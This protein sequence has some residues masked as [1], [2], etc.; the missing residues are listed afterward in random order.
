M[1]SISRRRFLAI[2]VFLG[3]WILIILARLFFLQILQFD[4]FTRDARRQQE[5]TVE[6]SPVRGVIYDRNH[7]PLAIS[8]EV[9]S[10][11]AVPGEIS[12]P[13]RTAKLL[14]AVLA[15]NAGDLQGRLQDSRS[16]RWVKRKVTAQEAARV[17]RLKLPGIYFQKESKRFY[18]KRELA[19]HVLGHVGLDDQGLAGIE[20]KFDE[21]LRGRPGKLLI[22]RD[23]RQRG[24][25]RAGLPPE[26]GENIVLTLD[27]NIQHIA[28]QELSAIVQKSRAIAGTVIVQDPHSGEILALVNQPSFNPN[29]YASHRADALRNWAISSAYEPGSTF[30][31]ITLAAALE[32]HLADP[33]EFIDCQMGSIILAGHRIR[34]HKPFGVLSVEQIFQ[35]SSDVGT[36]KLALRVGNE[37]MYRYLRLF[38]FGAPTG[39]ELPGE[40]IGLAKPPERWSKISIGAIAMGQEVGVT[41]LQMVTAASAVANGGWLVRPRMVLDP[42]RDPVRAARVS[43]RTSALPAAPLSARWGSHEGADRQR[44]LSPE[45]ALVLQQMMAQVVTIGTGKLARPEGYTAAGKTGTAQKID[46]ATRRY[47]ATDHVASFVGFAPVESPQFTI[48]VVL[49]SP[50]GYY[51]GGDIAA[52]VFKR[53]AEQIL[54]YRNVPALVPPSPSMLRA[55]RKIPAPSLVA[56]QPAIPQPTPL[57]SLD[58][59]VVA[60]NFLG[61]TVR[62]VAQESL[63]DNLE[64]RLIGSG[65]AYSQAPPPG[66]PLPEGQKIQ[67]W[68]RIGDAPPEL[69]PPVAERPLTRPDVGSLPSVPAR[70]SRQAAG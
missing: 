37:G 18:P 12:D 16:F 8:A 34:D 44:I 6:V 68:F 70:P 32:E 30:K 28:E 50:R 63:A 58:A 22:E 36:I 19:A 55:S 9:D 47:S 38:G 69:K 57:L 23:A 41:A 62:A 35:N 67:I 56:P 25:R 15:L 40:A 53:I 21:R 48:L 43:K 27:E 29:R 65:I 1:A 10:V 7:R 14:A 51:H 42:S 3:F 5:R 66:A 61:K 39:I 24:F 45:T 17:R 52:P 33:G 20:L 13:R 31:I 54:A 26:A 11:F 60:P 64:V 49:D 46:P 59:D 2:P 4:S